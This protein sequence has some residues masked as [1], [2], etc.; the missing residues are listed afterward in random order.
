MLLCLL[1]VIGI[2]LYCLLWIQSLLRGVS[3]ER[4]LHCCASWN[5]SCW[6][7]LAFLFCIRIEVVKYILVCLLAVIGISV[8][9]LLGTQSQ[10]RAIHS[11]HLRQLSWLYTHAKVLQCLYHSLVLSQETCAC[12]ISQGHCGETSD[13][14][15]LRVFT[16][17]CFL[18]R[19][20]FIAI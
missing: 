7:Y 6:L 9:C 14:C 3:S 1:A 18:S 5:S 19:S 17:P 8:Y 4:S 2:S 13:C 10:L 20:L 12:H 11:P 15:W 16:S